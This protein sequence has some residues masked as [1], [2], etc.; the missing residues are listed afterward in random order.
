LRLRQRIRR[1]STVAGASYPNGDLFFDGHHDTIPNLVK[2]PDKITAQSGNWSSGST[3]VGGVAPVAGE[4]VVTQTTHAIT[5]DVDATTAYAGVAIYGTLQFI[6]DDDTQLW[7]ANLLVGETGTLRVGTAGTPVESG[8]TAQIVITDTALDTEA[9]PSQY[10]TGFLALGKVEMHGAIKTPFIRLGAEASAAAESL[11]LSAGVTGWLPGDEMVLPDTRQSSVSGGTVWGAAGHRWESPL[12][13]TVSG[14]T[15]NLTAGLNYDH[16]GGERGFGAEATTPANFY[17]HVGNLSRNVIVRSEDGTGVRGHCMFLHRADI[18]IRYVRFKEL[19]RTTNGTLSSYYLKTGGFFNVSNT[20]PITVNS[21]PTTLNHLGGESVTISGAGGNT[22]ANGTWVIELTADPFVFTLV[23]SVG[24]GAYTVGTGQAEH[25]GTNQIGRYAIHVH[26]LYGPIATP[27][28]GYQHTLIGVVVDDPLP[29][30]QSSGTVGLP[31]SK[32]AITVHGSSYGLH[33][34][35]IAH[36]YAGANWMTEDGSES[37]NVFEANLSVNCVGDIN[38]RDRDG[39][40]GSGFFFQGFNHYV[41][42][43]VSAG[44]IGKFSGIVSGQGYYYNVSE[45]ATLSTK[46]PLYKGADTGDGAEGVEYELVNQKLQPL[47]ECSGNE[48]YGMIATGMTIWH[49]GTNGYETPVMEASLI[50][51]FTV[52]H[53]WEEGWFGYPVNNVTFDGYVIRNDPT[54]AEGVGWTGGDYWHANVTIRNADIRGSYRGIADTT[55]LHETLLIEDSHIQCQLTCLQMKTPSTPGSAS[56]SG[57]NITTLRN[58]VLEQFGANGSFLEISMEYSVAAAS[59]NLRVTDALFVEDYQ[60]VPGDDFRVYY[61]EQDGEFEM[62]ITGG[63]IDTGCPEAG[64]TNAEAYVAYNQDGTAKVGG[65]LSDPT[66]CAIAGAVAPDDATTRA[67]IDGL[68][69]EL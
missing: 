68:I 27:S 38:E 31:E 43:N 13:D 58:C 36:H 44:H 61:A 60:G 4:K 55:N 54:I 34:G 7:T 52:W 59:T 47:L 69:E 49:L 39:R 21:Y 19:G 5:Y 57:D 62:P 28:N 35:C 15:V 29:T 50:E 12:I 41:R 45:A 16:F 64:L 17:P 63:N 20:T 40:S 9:D 51:D 10:G 53:A 1:R 33:Q 18:D 56:D 25:V 6:T 11:T 32:W 22:A 26:H 23:D 66:G 3:W 42:D 24:N 8:V 14:T 67:G 48:A 30:H 65:S 46:N 37:F 2:D